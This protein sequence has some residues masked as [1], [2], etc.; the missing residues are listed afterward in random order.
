MSINGIFLYHD[1]ECVGN[2][3]L[4]MLKS[5]M[6]DHYYCNLM[7]RIEGFGDRALQMLQDNCANITT[8]GTYDFLQF[9]T[10]LKIFLDE[11]ATKLIH[12]FIVARTQAKLAGNRYTNEQLVDFI[13][14]GIYSNNGSGHYKVAVQLLMGKRESG[15]AVTFEAIENKFLA[16]DK[17]RP[18][19]FH[20]KKATAR[21]NTATSVESAAA[22]S[23]YQVKGGKKSIN[24]KPPDQANSVQMD[25]SYTY[26]SSNQTPH[27]HSKTVCWNCGKNG[28]M[29]FDY[30]KEKISD[31]N[32][33]ANQKKY[34]RNP[35]REVARGKATSTVVENI[36]P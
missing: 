27:D 24:H 28:H 21:G 32:G 35:K 23:F 19:N 8:M 10:A 25:D 4:L 13:L 36:A 20:Q 31:G 5:A 16:V 22:A 18:R 14:A 9:F 26:N 2:Q 3:A 6:V 15:E 12:R 17:R 33:V 11:T 34:D 29:S 1:P 7:S 30:R